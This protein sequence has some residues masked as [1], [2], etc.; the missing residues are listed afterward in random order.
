M[1]TPQ[2]PG[3]DSIEKIDNP[4]FSELIEI[5]VQAGDLQLASSKLSRRLQR[6]REKVPRQIE[7]LSH[8]RDSGQGAATA[9]I[10]AGLRKSRD[11]LTAKPPCVD[12][13]IVTI[14]CMLSAS[15]HPPATSGRAEVTETFRKALN[16]IAWEPLGDPESSNN[17]CFAMAVDIAKAALQSAQEKG[18]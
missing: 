15:S 10:G 14:N 18:K 2:S 12:A 5:I 6:F 9:D 16:H 13:A 11:F 3:A 7:S 4:D 17:D 8:T 1:T